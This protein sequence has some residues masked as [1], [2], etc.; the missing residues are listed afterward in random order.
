[1]TATT[2]TAELSDV[3]RRLLEQLRR[4]GTA[5]TRPGSGPMLW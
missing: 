4:G 2:A 3:K 1:M 5:Q